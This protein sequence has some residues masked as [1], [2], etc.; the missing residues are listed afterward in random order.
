MI[1][2][3]STESSATWFVYDITVVEA[4][5]SGKY[6]LQPQIGE[7]GADKEFELID[8]EGGGGGGG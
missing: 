3:W 5:K 6:N 2:G 4:G 1:G 7:S 8:G